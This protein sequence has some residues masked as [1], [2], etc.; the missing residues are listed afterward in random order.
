MRRRS[1]L[2]A[3]LNPMP[4]SRWQGSSAEILAYLVPMFAMDRLGFGDA[5]AALRGFV[6]AE[7]IAL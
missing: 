5:I 4:Q 1:T 3:W 7:V 6:T 2:I